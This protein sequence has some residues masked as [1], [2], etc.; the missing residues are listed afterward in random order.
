MEYLIS[1]AINDLPEF[2]ASIGAGPSSASGFSLSLG[3]N[4]VCVFGLP[5]G[6]FADVIFSCD[7]PLLP[8]FHSDDAPFHNSEGV[9]RTR[10]ECGVYSI[11]HLLSSW[12]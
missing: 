6:I 12:N 5:G 1:V 4:P 7:H 10:R 8:T 11:E 9:K 2:E 3:V